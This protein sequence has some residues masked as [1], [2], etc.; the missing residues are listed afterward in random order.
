MADPFDDK[1]A[2]VN[3]YYSQPERL[4]EIENVVLENEIVDWIF[5]QVNVI[6]EECDFDSIMK[7]N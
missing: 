1:E 5:N 4:A 3:W 7:A 2:F 6:E